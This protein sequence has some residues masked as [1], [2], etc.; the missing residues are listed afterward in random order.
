MVFWSLFKQLFGDLLVLFASHDAGSGHL[1]SFGCVVLGSQPSAPGEG[2][3]LA[4]C[5]AQ[6]FHFEAPEGFS[7]PDWCVSFPQRPRATHSAKESS[8]AG[9]WLIRARGTATLKQETPHVKNAL[10]TPARGALE[11]SQTSLLGH[12]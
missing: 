1:V 8:R 12:N 11:A 5:W 10:R 2:G 7:V 6:I 3:D 9:P 4:Q